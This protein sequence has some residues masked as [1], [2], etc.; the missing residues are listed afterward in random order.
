MLARAVERLEFEGLAT[1]IGDYAGQPVQ[2]IFARLPKPAAAALNKAIERAVLKSL[3]L[4]IH[5]LDPRDRKPPKTRLA[6]AFTGLSGALS[7][8]VGLVGL[9][10]E[11]P[12]TTLLMLRSIASIARHMGEDLA[13]AEA[14]LACVAVFAFGGHG[15]D[16]SKAE[17]GYYASRALL[18]KLASEMSTALLE[19]GAISAAASATATPAAAAFAGEVTTRFSAA[20]WERTAASAVPLVGAVGGASLNVIFTNHFNS[21]A[22]GHFT[23]RRL[24]RMYGEDLVRKTY[25]RLSAERRLSG[26]S[27]P[28]QKGKSP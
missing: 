21:I 3:D 1:K 7:G 23:V 12:V 2:K 15:F 13:T 4:A 8:A 25:A 26:K 17:V 16:K 6:A 28:A 5:S 10:I 11:L 18:G 19:R 24:E 20:V 9:P 27:G 14:R 22:W